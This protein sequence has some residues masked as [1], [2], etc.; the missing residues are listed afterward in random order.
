[1]EPTLSRAEVPPGR[2]YR[3]A[4]AGPCG[5][6]KS[7]LASL[8][9]AECD[10][11]AVIH[12]PKAPRDIDV[13]GA[14]PP[15]SVERFQRLMTVWRLDQVKLNSS[16]R[17]L[18]FDRTL[19]E[20]RDVFLQLY[21]RMGCI[22]DLQLERLRSFSM[23]A[24]ASIGIPDGIIVLTAAPEILRDRL[25]HAQNKRPPWLVEHI[26]LQHSLYS[27]WILKN[28][29]RALVLDSTRFDAQ[30]MCAMAMRYIATIVA[31]EHSSANQ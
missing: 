26:G 11:L 15:E 9:A 25:E 1:M 22:D 27:D 3:I 29:G 13:A 20:D 16:Y 2:Q 5:V 6:G 21:R 24:E 17:I 18:L 30:S 10:G 31:A 7:T 8:L 28:R 19:E 4:L 12:E 23:K 14:P